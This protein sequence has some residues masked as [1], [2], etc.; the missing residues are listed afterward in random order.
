LADFVVGHHRMRWTWGMEGENSYR[1]AVEEALRYHLRENLYFDLG[2]SWMV[3]TEVAPCNSVAVVQMEQASAVPSCTYTKDFVLL[4]SIP[5]VGM[6]AHLRLSSTNS[7]YL[8]SM[9][10]D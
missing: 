7:H 2:N 10:M 4:T 6:G 8:H 1:R 9:L 5:W 3:N